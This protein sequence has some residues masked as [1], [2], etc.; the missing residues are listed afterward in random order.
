MPGVL[1]EHCTAMCCRYI[2]VPIDEPETPQDFD[3]LR[4][5]LVHEGISVFV[6]DGEWF[7][8]VQA[9]CR[10]LQPDQR[11][12]IYDKR[13]RICREYDADNCDYHSGDYGWE[14]HFTCPEHLDDYVTA[15]RVAKRARRK[16]GPDGKAKRP[17]ARGRPK[18]STSGES[19][20]TRAKVDLRGVPL[21]LLGE[22]S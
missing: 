15:R 9:D 12:A 8:N 11:C 13:P 19:R 14:E 2:A 21:P 5:Y 7:L 6:E 22:G 3:D 16:A 18:R 17:G 10:H 20:Y 1:C 4:W